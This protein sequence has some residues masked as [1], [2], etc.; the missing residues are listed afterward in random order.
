MT[1]PP[2]ASLPLD[3]LVG[4]GPGTR[5]RLTRLEL[6]TVQD[7]L[8]HFPIR[9][10]DRT[11]ITPIAALTDG[12]TALIQGT[13]THVRGHRQQMIVDVSDGSG[14]A[15]LLFFH[16]TPAQRAALRPGLAVRC[17]GDVRTGMFGAEM[18]H[19]EYQLREHADRL[20]PV[21]AQL[22]AVYP[23]TD[24]LPQARLRAL[25]SQ[26]LTLIAADGDAADVDA[27]DVDAALDGCVRAALPAAPGYLAAL[28]EI[29]QP[30]AGTDTAALA[31][32]THVA[33]VRLA[34]EE[35]LAQQVAVLRNRRRQKLEAAAP[36]TAGGDLTQVM[37]T[38]TSYRLTNAQRRVVQ[39]LD[40]DLAAPRPMLRLVQGDV[41]CGK[42]VVAA[43]ACL[44][45][46]RSGYQVAV[47]VP[48]EVL[49]EQHL[50][51]FTTWLAPL[52]VR[53]ALLLG[54]RPAARQR[55]A[56]RARLAAGELDLIIGTQALIQS[57]VTFARLGLVVIDEQHR[58][59]VRQRLALKEKG[60]G[61]SGEPLAPHQLV[62]TATPIPRTL[63]QTAYADLD[64]S[65]IDELPPGRLPVTTV[66]LPDSRREA[67][68][69]RVAAACQA[70]RQAY[71][72][73]PLIETS[74]KVA[75]EAAEATAARL[76][77][78]LPRLAIG[79]AH[80]RQPGAER[81]AVLAAFA[82]G[83]LSL[84]VATTV[85]E[86]GLDVPNASLMVIENAER[87]GLA[88]LHQLRGR[89][90]RGRA[91][92]HCVLLYAPPLASHGRAR[93]ALL[94]ATNDGFRI[95]EQDLALRGPGEVLGT[96]QTGEVRLRAADLRRDHALLPAV[97]A[98]AA[99]LL[100]E[101]GLLSTLE[102]RWLPRGHD[103]VSV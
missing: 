37:A 7:L 95:A 41:G 103:Y 38:V 48:T 27:A 49:A 2:P 65:L 52:G 54:R 94:R 71:W 15:T 78:D 36:L 34:F 1:Q 76:R 75:A 10:E 33:R 55:E 22:T 85:I 99:A 30:A 21:S 3:R 13:V 12:T 11:R 64:I 63:A 25:V 32:G 16:F 73:C 80:G 62:L 87:L 18:V 86:V 40:H 68:I 66:S 44:R 97:Q 88:Q 84:L 102:S 81:A 47:M 39:E 58:F 53:V 50:L 59:G 17:W 92:S 77:A 61:A 93:L 43:H 28:G 24:G 89:V 96:R 42:T 26:A 69:A 100:D 8:F 19:P 57:P 60:R 29:H 4:V 91:Q 79:L 45:A 14:S 98:L 74:A 70:G 72:V 56:I 20:P 67:V 31:D 101:P 35:L 82:A 5:I 6:F 23:S 51:S 90:G 9:Y 46:V 83:T